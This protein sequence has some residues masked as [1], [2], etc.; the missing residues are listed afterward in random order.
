MTNRKSLQAG[1]HPPT[2]VMEFS[3]WD[4]N[5]NELMSQL[6]KFR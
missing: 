5:K 1:L 3:M 6:T 2:G 4:W